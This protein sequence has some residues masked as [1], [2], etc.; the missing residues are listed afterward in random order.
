MME[1]QYWN[2]K[3]ELPTVKSLVKLQGKAGW[4]GSILVAKAYHFYFQKVKD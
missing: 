2:T 3:I 4:S 1:F